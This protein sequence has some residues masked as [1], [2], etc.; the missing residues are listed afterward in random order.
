MKTRYHERIMEFWR[1]HSA[2][3]LIRFPKGK[4]WRTSS[5]PD[6]AGDLN[7]VRFYAATIIGDL[8]SNLCST[9]HRLTEL[10]LGFV[11][12]KSLYASG[13]STPGISTASEELS[14]SSI[15]LN[16]LAT[17]PGAYIV[18]YHDFFRRSLLFCLLF[19]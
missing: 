14:I 3:N 2:A 15:S 4:C 12:R 7:A 6:N 8:N 18:F 17:T 9:D 5:V 10:R 1:K 19:G 16:Q 11:I 13:I